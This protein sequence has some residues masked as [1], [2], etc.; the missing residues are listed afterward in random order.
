MNDT[1]KATPF[2]FV[3]VAL[4]V[5]AL[6]TAG[7]AYWAA[8]LWRDLMAAETEIAQLRVRSAQA[9]S[10]ETLQARND[11]LR[12]RVA[13][14]EAQ[15]AAVPAP[16]APSPPSSPAAD[17]TK[18]KSFGAMASAMLNTPVMREMMVRTQ[19]AG[20]ER[21]F[22][23]LMNQ[24]GLSPEDRTRF[25]DL[26]SDKQM[27]TIDTG[28]KM[29]S[30][31]LSADE[32]AAVV[33]QIKDANAASEAKIRDFFG[34]DATYATYQDYVVQQPL[35]AQ[36]TALGTSLANAGQPMTAEQSNALATVMSDARKNVIF[37]GNF[38][39]PTNTDPQTI[40][41]GPAMDTYFQEQAQL[42]S[43]I[44]DRAAT[45]LSPEQV[46]A[47][48]QAQTTRLEQTRKSMEMA[49]QVM[50]GK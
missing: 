13:E 37:S 49:R 46:A 31:N 43:Q 50:S 33:Q 32:R 5:L 14:L 1:P 18:A 29:M 24:L 2:R 7:L 34:N 23:D 20:L 4:V 10:A 35:R 21:R 40:M 48:R 44:A 47:L 15:R 17:P 8:R 41:N 45:F 6:V 30:G 38:T 12:A 42:Q 11:A 28:L 3:H 39:D 9:V 19:K 26:L 22:A 27:L 25:I 36:V 16:V